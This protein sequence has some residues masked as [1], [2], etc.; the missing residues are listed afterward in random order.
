MKSFREDLFCI[1]AIRNLNA[2]PL[3]A[4]MYISL[5]SAMFAHA[6]DSEVHF[7]SCVKKNSGFFYIKHQADELS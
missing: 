5:K 6:G 1:S 2:K 7:Y 4:R 3:L